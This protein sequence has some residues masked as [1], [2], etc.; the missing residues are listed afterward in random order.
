MNLDGLPLWL[1]IALGIFLGRSLLYLVSIA[2]KKAY[3]KWADRA[4]KKKQVRMLE[5]ANNSMDQRI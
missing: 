1:E 3:W 5:K 4:R 2:G